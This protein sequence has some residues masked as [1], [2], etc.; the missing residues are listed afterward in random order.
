MN[1][2]GK[3]DSNASCHTE[4]AGVEE[5]C[6]GFL[7]KSPPSR[8]IRNMKSWKRRF[9]VLSKTNDSSHELKYYKSTERDKPI[10]SI[11][12]S[13]ITM[14]QVNPEAN[15]DFEWICKTFK[16]SPDTVLLMKTENPGAKVQREFFFIGDTSEEV[17]RWFNFLF[18]AIKNNKFE[19]QTEPQITTES[20]ANDQKPCD[21]EETKVDGQPPLPPRKK[22]ASEDVIARCSQPPKS[23]PSATPVYENLKKEESLDET[24][25]ESN[26][27]MSSREGMTGTSEDSLLD[28][29]TKAFDK[30]KTPQTST[31]SHGQSETHTLVEKEICISHLDANSLVITEEEG[32]PCVSKCGEI[33]ASCLFHKGDQILAVNDLLTD[34]VEE[35]QTYLKRLSKSEVKLT[36]RRLPDSIP[37]HCELC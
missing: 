7:I 3:S 19:P 4:A 30:M 1:S 26:E 27:D 14:L 21:T 8:Q 22:S 20:N 37:L 28:C 5:V 18:R 11:D 15:P 23:S 24:A 34:T 25:V 2:R 6:K 36:I 29:V 35:V 31:E 13:T 17:D 33:Q 10:K 32:K 12:S 16:C 9:F